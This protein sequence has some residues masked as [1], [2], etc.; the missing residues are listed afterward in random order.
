MKPVMHYLHIIQLIFTK[1][2]VLLI[3][4][5]L[6]IFYSSKKNVF[7]DL[8]PQNQHLYFYLLFRAFITIF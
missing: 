2:I 1:A 4:S 6:F 8:K 3:M 5:V 7:E